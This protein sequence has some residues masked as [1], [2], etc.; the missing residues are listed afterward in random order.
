MGRIQIPPIDTSAIEKGDPFAIREAFEAYGA[1]LAQLTADAAIRTG[2][3]R[4][5]NLVPANFRTDNPWVWTVPADGISRAAFV[6]IDDLML[7]SLSVLGTQL[8]NTAF[9]LEI[10]LPQG[11]L[12]TTSAGLGYQDHPAWFWWHESSVPPASHLGRA[13]GSSGGRSLRCERADGSVA[14]FPA[15]TDLWVQV[16]AVLQVTH[17]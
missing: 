17:G 11:Y 2:R 16:F 9:V 15:L 14:T 10:D 4:E 3:W 13:Y 7:Y 6:I 8:N 1:V 12:L 5:A